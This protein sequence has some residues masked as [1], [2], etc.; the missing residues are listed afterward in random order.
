MPWI[1]V[2]AIFFVVWFLALFVALP[3]GVRRVE[4]PEPGQDTGA[5]QQPYMWH[6][7][8]A[9]LLI[10]TVVTAGLWYGLDS[11]LI[12]FRS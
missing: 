8:G 2:L 1:S 10:A 9:S 4:S 6:K 5:P 3:F 11:G 7:V 12:N